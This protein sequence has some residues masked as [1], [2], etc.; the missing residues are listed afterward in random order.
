[1]FSS[2]TIL[3]FIATLLLPIAWLI[4]AIIVIYVD[5]QMGW[6]RYHKESAVKID[7]SANEF[8]PAL[9]V[10]LFSKSKKTKRFGIT[11][12]TLSYALGKLRQDNDFS[13][14]A[15]VVTFVIYLWD[16]DHYEREIKFYEND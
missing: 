14:F 6:R 7:I 9:W 3:F 15:K 1:M 4:N 2:Y 8:F 12:Q 10:K 16:K 13:G 5:K 11:G